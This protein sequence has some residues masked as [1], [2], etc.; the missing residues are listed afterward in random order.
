MTAPAPSSAYRAK[1]RL[2]L[3]LET[4]KIPDGIIIAVPL[5]LTEVLSLYVHPIC[6][7]KHIHTYRIDNGYGSR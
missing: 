4:V 2:K 1:N 3:S 7:L 6:C 5:S